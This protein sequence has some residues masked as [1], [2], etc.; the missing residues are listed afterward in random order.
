MKPQSAKGKGRIGQKEVRQKFLDAFPQLED[1]DIL[2]RS[3]GA[4][5]TDLHLSPKA[6]S[7]IPFDVEVKYQETT[8]PWE[9]FEQAR[10]NSTNI[11]LVCFRRNR[12]EWMALITLDDLVE[13]IRDNNNETTAS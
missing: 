12:S 7:L 5:G 3:S 8:K 10:A 13:L 4:S 1:D 2:S 9:W 6:K 11:P